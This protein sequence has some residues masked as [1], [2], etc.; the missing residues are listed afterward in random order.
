MEL[1]IFSEG[2]RLMKANRFATLSVIVLAGLCTLLLSCTKEK[3]VKGFVMPKGDAERGQEVFVAFNCYGCHD[4]AGVELPQRGSE[5][6]FIVTLG[7]EVL[8]VKDYGELLTAIVIPDHVVSSK[9]R[10]KLMQ[11]GKD[12]DQSPMPYFGDIMTVTELTDLTE[13]LHGQYTL[14][15]RDYYRG[16]YYYP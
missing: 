9:Y 6:P 10:A 5:P 8:K 14:M 12:P 4:V 3:P 11:A 1:L 2:D 16:H 13:F 7:G 15:A